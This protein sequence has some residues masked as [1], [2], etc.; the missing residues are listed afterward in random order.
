MNGFIG[1]EVYQTNLTYLLK[2][3]SSLVK[4]NISFY[5]AFSL[6][7]HGLVAK[8]Q[9]ETLV[10]YV[11]KIKNCKTSETLKAAVNEI[12]ILKG[13]VLI[14]CFRDQYFPQHYSIFSSGV[15]K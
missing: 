12:V 7:T 3:T 5:K 9:Y 15:G 13:V 11:I 4:I 6:N 10:V 14:G 8:L 1:N 2:S